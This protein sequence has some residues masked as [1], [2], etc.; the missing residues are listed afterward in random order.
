MSEVPQETGRNEKPGKREDFP[1]ERWIQFALRTIGLVGC[2]AALAG[3]RG[4]IFGL[5]Q[6]QGAV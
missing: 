4:G 3:R 2:G 1:G 5:S 6:T